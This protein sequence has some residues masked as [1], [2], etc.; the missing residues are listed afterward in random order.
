MDTKTFFNMKGITFKFLFPCNNDDVKALKFI[1]S[2]NL[3]ASND[4]FL[5]FKYACNSNIISSIPMCKRN[6]Q[7]QMSYDNIIQFNKMMGKCFLIRSQTHKFHF[8]LDRYRNQHKPKKFNSI[9]LLQLEGPQS[10]QFSHIMCAACCLLFCE[11][12][13][14]LV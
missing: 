8:P 5:Y 3:C 4:V 10:M 9:D 7:C 2:S 13:V 14:Y 11:Y 6:A 12:R 1:H